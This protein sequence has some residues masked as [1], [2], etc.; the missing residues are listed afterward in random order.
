MRGQRNKL[1]PMKVL[2]MITA[3]MP[4]PTGLDLRA[5]MSLMPVAAIKPAATAPMP[6]KAP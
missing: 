1:T 2:S 6:R 3:L 5:G 4:I